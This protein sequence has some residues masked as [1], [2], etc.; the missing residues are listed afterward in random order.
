MAGTNILHPQGKCCNFTFHRYAN[1]SPGNLQLIP[2]LE[3]HP[4]FQHGLLLRF[5]QEAKRV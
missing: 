1:L 4:E 3:I 5:E 2:L